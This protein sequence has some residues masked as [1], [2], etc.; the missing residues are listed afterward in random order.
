MNHSS[1]SYTKKTFL[2]RYPTSFV[3]ADD[4]EDKHI[5]YKAKEVRRFFHELQEFLELNKEFFSRFGKLMTHKIKTINPENNCKI[6]K[7]GY[8]YVGDT[9]NVYTTKGVFQ[10]NFDLD[11][12][13]K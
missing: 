6:V 7:E 5:K 3:Y 13:L 2:K 4:I 10:I 1:Y 8:E 11:D 12:K 9:I